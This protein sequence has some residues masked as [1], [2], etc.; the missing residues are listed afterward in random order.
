MQGKQYLTVATMAIVN[1]TFATIG[2]ALFS[3]YINGAGKVMLGSTQVV[4]VV[5]LLYK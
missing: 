5:V 4:L 2:N 1:T 3:Q